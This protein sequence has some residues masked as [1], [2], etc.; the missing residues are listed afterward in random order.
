MKH[1]LINI[2]EVSAIWLLTYFSPILGVL[3]GI[4]VLVVIDFITGIMAANKRGEA[5]RS[6][7][8]KPTITKGIVYM[9]AIIVAHVFEKHFSIGYDAVKI[10]GGLIAL[11]ELKSFDE[12]I[13]DITGSSLF[14]KIIDRK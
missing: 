3:F 11:I 5:I 7:K 12:N 2:I 10:V 1:K 8:M 9:F 6:N 14:K 13:K 4:G